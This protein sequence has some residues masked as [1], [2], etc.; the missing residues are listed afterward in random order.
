MRIQFHEDTWGLF[1]SGESSWSFVNECF[2][3]L[4]FLVD[5]YE[6]HLETAVAAQYRITTS[7][8][9]YEVVSLVKKAIDAHWESCSTLVFNMQICALQHFTAL[10]V[11][12]PGHLAIY[13]GQFTSNFCLLRGFRDHK[14]CWGSKFDTW[15]HQVFKFSIPNLLYQLEDEIC[16]LFLS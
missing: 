10:A 11:Y 14:L 7:R 5:E 8:T 13:P 4:K 15:F 16:N 2:V 1:Y 6:I 3:L 9:S 12:F